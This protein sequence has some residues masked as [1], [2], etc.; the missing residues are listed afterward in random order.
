MGGFCGG[1]GGLI[2]NFFFGGIEV[3]GAECLRWF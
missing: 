2:R 1:G 3:G